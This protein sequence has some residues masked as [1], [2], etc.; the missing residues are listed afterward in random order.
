MYFR[1]NGLT[2]MADP[3]FNAEYCAKPMKDKLLDTISGK[4]TDWDIPDSMKEYLGQSINGL[5]EFVVKVT[6]GFLSWIWNFTD[7]TDKAVMAGIIV[8]GIWAMK[9]PAIRTGMLVLGASGTILKLSIGGAIAAHLF[10]SHRD[11][12]EV[13]DGQEYLHIG[14]GTYTEQELGSNIDRSMTL[15]SLKRLAGDSVAPG[16]DRSSPVATTVPPAPAPAQ[17]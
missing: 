9:N 3:D 17:P 2:L 7:T 4:S 6:K 12:V 10:R 1:L 16:T 8:G 5:A 11:K 13:K 15:D 14:D